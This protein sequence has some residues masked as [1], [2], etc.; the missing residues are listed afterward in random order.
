MMNYNLSTRFLKSN[1]WIRSK[2]LC[3][4]MSHLQAGWACLQKEQNIFHPAQK[5]GIDFQRKL[6]N[7]CYRSSDHL[8]GVIIFLVGHS[9][10][11]VFFYVSLPHIHVL[12]LHHDLYEKFSVLYTIT[13]HP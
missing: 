6:S 5:E 2:N 1:Y 10:D 12:K 9:W 13:E 3:R 8:S 11:F 7:T 4:F